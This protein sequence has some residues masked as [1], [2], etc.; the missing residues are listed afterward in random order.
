MHCIIAYKDG[1]IFRVVKNAI[2]QGRAIKGEG[3]WVGKPELF[4]IVWT[5]QEL[6][7][8]EEGRYKETLADIKIIDPPRGRVITDKIDNT[9]RAGLQE[10][11]EAISELTV[12]DIKQRNESIQTLDEAKQMLLHHE[13]IIWA[14]SQLIFDRR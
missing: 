8:D 9:L 14:I 12:E 1:T 3:K 7:P 2:R 5:E 13:Y 11:L 4:D 6:I 10:R